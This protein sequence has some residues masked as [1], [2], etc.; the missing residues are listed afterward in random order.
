M[1]KKVCMILVSVIV[2]LCVLL[3]VFKGN[4]T[5]PFDDVEVGNLDKVIIYYPGD[6]ETEVTEP[7]RLE[8][9]VQ[10]LQ[11]MKLRRTLARDKDGYGIAM[12][13]YDSAGVKQRIIISSTDVT[14]DSKCYTCDR[15]YC[16]DFRKLCE[17]L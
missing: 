1:K 15:D 14:I 10:L 6:Q 12:D 9:I 5:K 11:A 8:K 7:D 17:E 2:V 4:V 13:I 16:E 3:I